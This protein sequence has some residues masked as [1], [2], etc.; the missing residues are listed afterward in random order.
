MS[1]EHYNED[2]SYVILSLRSW[3]RPLE[4]PVRRLLLRISIDLPAQLPVGT[5]RSVRP[6]RCSKSGA[7]VDVSACAPGRGGQP[8]NGWDV[9]I[10]G[11]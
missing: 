3:G 4:I 8:A 7:G 1:T 2:S 6:A 5:E 10:Q 9:S 11:C